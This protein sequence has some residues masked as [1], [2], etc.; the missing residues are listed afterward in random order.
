MP[1]TLCVVTPWYPAPNKPSQ[2]SFVASMTAAAQPWVGRTQVLHHEDWLVPHGRLSRLALRRRYGSLAAATVPALVQGV[3]LDRIP[4]LVEPRRPW[5]YY[6]RSVADSVR[7][8]R[9]GR[10][11]DAAVVHAHVGLPG[12]LVALEN[13]APGTR[14]VVTE[15]AS[16]LAEVLEQPA[17][18]AL[19]DELMHRADAWTC[20]SEVLRR[21]L[22]E[23]FPHHAHRVEVLPNAVDVD[24]IP[25][26]EEPV[27]TPR[28]WIYV[29]SLIERKGPLRLVE[30]FGRARRRHPDLELTLVGDGGQRRAVAERI[31]ELGLTAS[32][33]LLPPVPPTQVFRLLAEHDLLVHPSHHETFGMTPVEALATGTP[34]LVAR[35]PAAQEVLRG[36]LPEAGGLFDIG[37][38]SDEIVAGYESLLERFETVDALAARDVVRE[39]FG[40]EAV[41]RRLAALYHPE[42]PTPRERP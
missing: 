40:Y 12:A 6:A 26:R 3:W 39:R 14:V 31:K 25:R 42:T 9:G 8:A 15:H 37:S 19:Y 23:A 4:V 41:G 38:G 11:I 29:G 1:D 35:Y 32:A 28:R 17:A 16:Y 7:V 22:V 18:R 33:R 36:A 34:V 27:T 24:A 2:G 13:A 10:R 20:V 21:Q 5:A 30:A